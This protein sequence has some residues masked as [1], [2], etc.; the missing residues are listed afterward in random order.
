MLPFTGKI[1]REAVIDDKDDYPYHTTAEIKNG[2]IEGPWEEFSSF[3]GLVLV[4]RGS[5]KS[6]YPDGEYTSYYEDGRIEEKAF[7]VM[8]KFNGEYKTFYQNG[9]L[10]SS[11][12]FKDHRRQGLAQW[13][14]ENGNLEKETEYDLSG[15]VINERHFDK[16]GNLIS[17]KD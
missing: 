7:F 12:F 10:K 16:D 6:G 5:A 4:S 13:F 3:D 2:Y 17:N 14:Y 9:N 8:G 11:G 15:N 1:T